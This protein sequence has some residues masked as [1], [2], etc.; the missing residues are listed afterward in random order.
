M[1]NFRIIAVIIGTIF[2][3]FSSSKAQNDIVFENSFHKYY[4]EYELNDLLS[5]S[6]SD[7]TLIPLPERLNVQQYFIRSTQIIIK[8][9]ATWPKSAPP[10]TIMDDFDL[11]LSF[12]LIK[13]ETNITFS[14]GPISLSINPDKPL[15][16]F[17]DNFDDIIMRNQTTLSE[18]KFCLKIEDVRDLKDN[19]LAGT[20]SWEDILSSLRLSVEYTIEYAIDAFSENFAP[21]VNKAIIGQGKRVTFSWNNFE[22]KFPT[23]HFQLAKLYNNSITDDENQQITADIDWNK[24]LNIYTESNANSLTLS[25][26]E[27]T[28]F[29]VWRVRPLGTFY[30]GKEA[31]ALNF[32]RWS[33]DNYSVI[34]NNH[35][36][37]TSSQAQ[38]NNLNYTPVFFFQDPDQDKNY[39]H[40]RT[41]TEGNKTSEQITFAN[42]LL[43][44]K[45]I[46]NSIRSQNTTLITQIIPDLDGRPSL[47]TLPIPIPNE[48]SEGLGSM[49]YKSKF[50]TKSSRSVN[51]ELFTAWD[52]DTEVKVY[53]PEKV[54]DGNQSA[55]SYYSDNNP[56][57]NVPGAQGFPY[58]RTIY[59]NDGTG[60]V[61][62]QSGVGETHMVN[63]QQTNHGGRTIRTLYAT[64]SETELIRIFGDE[65]P[66]NESVLKTITIDQNNT[67]QIVYT[68]RSGQ[69]IATAVSFYENGTSSSLS[70]PE[71]TFNSFPVEDNAFFN[72]KTDKGFISTKR[73]AL[74][75]ETV[76]N[77]DYSVKCIIIEGLCVNTEIDCGYQLEIYLHDLTN[78]ISDTLC[79]QEINSNCDENGEIRLTTPIIR[80]LG[81]GNYIVEKRLIQ[82]ETP[83]AQ[84]SVA[85]E[86]VNE[87]IEPLTNLIYSWYEQL[88][89][90]DDI[91][92]FKDKLDTL[93][94]DVANLSSEE[95]INEYNLPSTFEKTDEH[96]VFPIYTTIS[97]PLS[98][99]SFEAPTHVVVTSACC[100]IVIPV[101]FVPDIVKPDDDDY[102]P[103]ERNNIDGFQPNDYYFIHPE[104]TEFP[105]DLEGYSLSYLRFAGCCN[106]EYVLYGFPL[107]A[108]PLNLWQSFAHRIN[109]STGKLSLMDG[110]ER[111][112]LNWMVYHMLM[113]EYTVDGSEAANPEVKRQYTFE[114]IVDCWTSVLIN[115]RDLA[116]D[117]QEFGEPPFKVSDN[118]DSADYKA[119][120]NPDDSR[121]NEDIHDDHVDDEFGDLSWDMRLLLGVTG[122]SGDVRDAQKK[123][124]NGANPPAALYYPYHLI[125]Q[126]LDCTSYK[127]A[128]I[129]TPEDPCPLS[130]DA[131]SGKNYQVGWGESIC[132]ATGNTLMK[133]DPD[134]SF[135][136]SNI[137]DEFFPGVRDPHFAF[138]YFTYGY[139]E[140][141]IFGR[142]VVY[143][144]KFPDLE[145]I[146]CFEDPNICEDSNGNPVPCCP[147]E[148]DSLC[149]FCGIGIIKCEQTHLEWS[150]GQR[151]SFFETIRNYVEQKIEVDTVWKNVDCDD[152]LTEAHPNDSIYNRS[153]IE[154]GMY[155]LKTSCETLCEQ[156]RQI[157][158]DSLI[159]VLERNCYVIGECRTDDPAQAYI[160]S[161]EDI[162]EI[163]NSL[164]SQCQS[165]C[166]VKTYR[167]NDL[168]QC[169]PITKAKTQFGT[170]HLITYRELE[171]GVGDPTDFAKDNCIEV[172]EDIWRC[173]PLNDQPSYTESILRQQAMHWLPEIS[174]APMCHLNP[175][176][177]ETCPE[178]FNVNNTITDISDVDKEK[179]RL[180][181]GKLYDPTGITKVEPIK[182]DAISI[183]TSINY[184]D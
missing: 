69:T 17:V 19:Y 16:A 129:L 94:N 91:I 151:Y 87:Q 28:G 137:D 162:D 125:K 166:E 97:S 78:G 115:L 174:V 13:P 131:E 24:A 31:N 6:E 134:P 180:R 39:I 169:R 46:Q 176:C 65:A 37:L 56:D 173:S 38:L 167:C 54:E 154:Y 44:T 117:G 181:A 18:N 77:I 22:R 114:D 34:N 118:V 92:E 70:I 61:R 73:I 35:I 4:K 144:L 107:A 101:G 9:Y 183:K 159:S 139:E 51:S 40:S 175:N 45:Q 5:M 23:Y 20:A 8:F 157:F 50:M 52:Y 86:R 130:D 148:P 83:S 153:W 49:T 178:G 96:S 98:E 119:N 76:V 47:T 123:K 149:N 60:R 108:I 21:T 71:N 25:I 62:E 66:S 155:K 79:Q 109:P 127:F 7:Y 112:D 120:N 26:A 158:K 145:L 156:R 14:E 121:D 67:A 15:S 164:V 58:S 3:L 102:T 104:N 75:K 33:S 36:I 116:C 89:T 150:A 172:G 152:F 41:F 100:H 80:T 135:K 106:P 147:D 2:V 55:F 11:E 184:D 42:S 142:A 53:N 82:D 27:G 132:S 122:A 29:Y 182:S 140:R 111:G 88:E 177:E 160:I 141:D 168:K 126:F 72:V 103:K 59:F 84:I 81:P 74:L 133:Y 113:D 161:L 32:G 170:T 57:I 143:D 93:K 12:S 68:D 146:T 136:P 90:I 43:Q 95:L 30:D 105:M 163:V 124:I 128:K 110:W 64:P 10:A 99:E 165:Q 63:E 138:K 171:F 48:N 179:L 85:V 1:K